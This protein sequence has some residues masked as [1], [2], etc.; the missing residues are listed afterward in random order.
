MFCSLV[1]LFA[2]F[3]S[4]QE[5]MKHLNLSSNVFYKVPRELGLLLQMEKLDLCNQVFSE[6]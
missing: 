4:M 6:E 2:N 3:Y 5:M 1:Q